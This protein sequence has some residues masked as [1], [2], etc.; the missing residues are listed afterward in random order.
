MRLS[1]IRLALLAA[2]VLVAIAGIVAS[3]V[4]L[5][6]LRGKVLGENSLVT[7]AKVA[8]TYSRLDSLTAKVAV[9]DHYISNLT[10][11]LAD[12][13]DIDSLRNAYRNDE[14]LRTGHINFVAID[15]TALPTA[16]DAER[17]FV[18]NYTAHEGFSID[19]ALRVLPE[20]PAFVAPLRG[21]VVMATDSGTPR[22]ETGEGS[23]EV[24]SIARGTV[25]ALTQTPGNT[26]E[27]TV[28]HPD[29]YLSR[30]GNASEAYVKEGEIVVSGQKLGKYAAFAS[31]PFEFTLYRDG[32]KLDPF[33]YI[34]F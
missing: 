34:N 14:A 3:V 7:P 19:A 30:Y 6:P 28:Q 15:T 20:A 18:D 9:N 5:T 29:G 10:R 4:F 32:L 25:V 33:L 21:A 27:I 17:N 22:Y 11:I 1:A 23:A 2:L 24:T 31:R 13:I 12:D 8:E 16:S 26:V